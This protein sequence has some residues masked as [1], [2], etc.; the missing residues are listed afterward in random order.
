[1]KR[2]AYFVGS[3]I[4]TFLIGKTWASYQVKKEIIRLFS[5]SKATT[6]KSFSYAQ[7]NGL[8]EP[9]QRYFKHVLKEGQPYINYVRLQYD[10]QFKTDL[11][12]NWVNI[13]GEQY[14]TATKPGFIWI[15]TTNLFTARDMFLAGHG[16]LKVR[17]FS[18]IKVAEGSGPKYDQGELLRWLGE[19]AWFPT[20][21]LPS[22][23][24]NWSPIDENTA[25]LTFNYNQQTVSYKVSINAIG[26]ITEMETK[27]YMGE[28]SLENWIGR[29]R[30]YQKINGVIIP[31]EAEGI[32]R[33]KSGDHSYANFQVKTIEYN[34]P[35][36]F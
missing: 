18:L 15:G 28:E 27:R 22:K 20:N 5:E 32:W 13:K 1:M 25:L 8:P 4:A 10:G 14:F 34:N 30:N 33:L 3:L 24:L 21:L 23:N 17:L 16:S 9:V 7:L 6:I 29:Y 36:L 2:T 31:T 26:E 35:T 12:K 11:K 19:S